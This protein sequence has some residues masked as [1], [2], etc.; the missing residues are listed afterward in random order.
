MHWSIVDVVATPDC[1][2]RSSGAYE[3]SLHVSD[4]NSLREHNMWDLLEE[5]GMNLY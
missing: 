1:T 4:S 3:V 5:D 2:C